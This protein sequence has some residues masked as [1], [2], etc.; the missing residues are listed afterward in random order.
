MAEDVYRKLAEHLDRLPGGFAPSES[1][2]ELRVLER[3]FTPEEA[4]LA[5]HLSLDKEEA[6]VIAERAS[7]SCAE[8]E[9][10]LS[11]MAQ[12]GLILSL[13][14][15][16][17]PALYQTV[18]WVVGIYEFQVNNLSQ[19]LLQTRRLRNG[20]LFKRAFSPSF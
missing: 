17:G 8:A 5:V 10:L 20:L 19:G 12:K 2:A 3:L 4:E 1:G 16:D 9:Q 18:P 7:L 14:P 11:E 15:D 13:E 6:R